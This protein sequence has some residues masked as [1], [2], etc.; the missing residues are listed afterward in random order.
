MDA[1]E[2]PFTPGAGTPPPELAGREDMIERALV[3]VDRQRRGHPSQGVLLIGL[4]GVGKTVVLNQVRQ[5]AERAGVNV[6]ALEA[7][8]GRLAESVAQQLRSVLLKLSR[9]ERAKEAVQRA[10]RALAGFAGTWKVAIQD[11]EIQFGAAPEPGLADYGDLELDLNDLLAAA[12]G[13]AGAAGSCIALTIDELQYLDK[14]ELGSLLAALHGAAQRRLPLIMIG[15][16]LPQVRGQLG[17]AKTYSERMF[18]VIEIGPL[19]EA[20]TRDAV[21]KPAE[22]QGVEVE[23]GA[24]AEIMRRTRGY[25]YFVQQ[26]ARHAW[27]AAEAPRIRAADVKAA[28][29]E[30]LEGLDTAFFRIRLDRIAPR[31]RLYLRAMAELGSEPCRSREVAEVLGKTVTDVATAR[32]RLIKK[33]MLW[34][35]SYGQTAFTVP[36]FDEFMK[37]MMPEWERPAG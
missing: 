6:V 13:A 32:S 24:V 1:A 37:R 34:S 21:A 7:G 17:E 25:P 23:A 27:D 15:A 19:A 33:G 26:W 5:D 29:G 28:S 36:M 31:E 11:V 30:A 3:A 35:P 16:G 4:R 10:L 14:E 22:A 8:A 9:R 18:E 12:A 20:E 2:N